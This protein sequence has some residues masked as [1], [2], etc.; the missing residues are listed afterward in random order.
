MKKWKKNAHDFTHVY[1][2]SQSNDARF[3]RYIRSKVDRTFCHFF[4]VL[5]PWWSRKSNFWKNEKN[6]RRYYPF[7]HVY[8]KWR[9]F[10]VW[11]LKYKTRQ[12]ECFVIL[13]HFL[14]SHHPDDPENQ[15]F[16]KLKKSPGDIIILHMSTIND[17]HMMY[18]S[19]D[20]ERDGQNLFSFW[21]NFCPFTPPTIRKTKVSKKWKKYLEI[22]S[23]YTCAP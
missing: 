12:T 5:L 20:M 21:V 16:E 23:F 17:N 9:S 8:H 7:T 14:L 13:D 11:F 15:N 19:W 3:L 2:K 18:G 6:I 4:T 22:L 10:D 1:Q